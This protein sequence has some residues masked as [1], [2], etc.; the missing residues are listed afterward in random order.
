LTQAAATKPSLDELLRKLREEEP[1]ISEHQSQADPETSA[2]PRRSARAPSPQ[3][4]SLLR[5]DLDWIAMKALEKDR[6]RRYG[7]PLEL[8]A[9]IRRYLN[10]EPVVARPASVAYQLRKYIRRH[11]VAV[12]SRLDW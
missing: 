4:V 10:H 8:A 11:R 1:P 7:A 5:G 3:L 9:D 2:R 6:T 12:G